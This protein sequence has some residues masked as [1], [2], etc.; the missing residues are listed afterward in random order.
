MNGQ[1]NAEE[2]P[3][4]RFLLSSGPLQADAVA[5]VLDELQ[6]AA[7]VVRGGWGREVL[8]VARVHGVALLVEDDL[9]RAVDA[10]GVH[11]TEPSKVSDARAALARGHQGRLILGAAVGF[12][13]HEAMVAGEKGADYVGFGEPCG[14]ADEA[15]F[16]LVAW[17]RATTILPCLAYAADTETAIRLARIGTDFIGV[18]SAVWDHPEGPEIAARDLSAAIATI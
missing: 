1:A 5:A 3:K 17:W 4:P 11:L 7:M 15:V 8:E 2:E 13:R 16:E 6:P 14:S 10:D 12:S 9:A 18:S